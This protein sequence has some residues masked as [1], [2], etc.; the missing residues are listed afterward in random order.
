VSQWHPAK[1]LSIG[2][3]IDFVLLIQEA[4]SGEP[5]LANSRGY[6]LRQQD[7]KYLMNW[8]NAILL[9]DDYL[10]KFDQLPGGTYW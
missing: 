4:S 1:R 3:S 10:S 7:K 2:S 8:L 5:F 9:V 6:F